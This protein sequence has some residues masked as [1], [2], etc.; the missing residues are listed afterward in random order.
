MT[1]RNEMEARILAD[2][3]IQQG[4][5]WGKPRSGHPEGSVRKHV[6]AILRY[7]DRQ[8]WK[9]YKEDLRILALIHDSFKFKERVPTGFLVPTLS[10][11]ARF[12]AEYYEQL[13][14]GGDRL[15]DV[16][17]HHDTPWRFYKRYR[18][19]KFNRELF[20]SIFS[21][22]DLDLLIR[23]N[24]A[25]ACQRSAAP[26]EWFQ[27]MIAKVHLPNAPKSRIAPEQPF[28]VAAEKQRSTGESK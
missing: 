21:E 27:D 12:A 15:R 1:P 8:D 9:Q 14:P 19:G 6:T 3:V 13:N 28:A 20:I 26:A 4:L 18:E 5:D 7:I 25:D 17:L 22:L 2:P 10:N 24:Y 16:L 23:F 11:H